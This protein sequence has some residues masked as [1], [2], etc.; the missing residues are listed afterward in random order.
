MFQKNIEN[1]RRNINMN[2]YF[3]IQKSNLKRGDTF[4]PEFY[5][6]S[7]VIKKTNLKKGVQYEQLGNNY[8]SDGEHSAIPR[9]DK[10]GIRYLY[11]RNI[12]E[13]EID[14]D[15]IS[16]LPY[17]D[18]EDYNKMTRTHLQDNDVLTAIVG[19][20][21]KSAIY[22]KE[23]VG[24]A[25]IPRHIAK[26]RLSND[27]KI[28]PEYLS[29]F[30]R[31][32]YGKAQL[33]SLTT[34]NL[35]PLLSLKN[36]KTVEIPI[37]KSDIMN[38]ITENERLSN[39]YLIKSNNYIKE[40]QE[41]F[42]ESLGFDIKKIKGD[43]SFNIKFNQIAKNDI[44]TPNHYNVKFDNIIKELDKNKGYVKLGD[45]IQT[46]QHGDEIG[47]D[48]YID[49]INKSNDS[50]PFIR[51]SDIVNYKVDQYPDYYGDEEAYQGIKQSV[52]CNDVI[53]TKDGKIGSVGLITKNDKCILSSGI[54]ILRLNNN[55][56]KQGLT[57]EYLFTAL[58]IIEIGYYE[59]IRRTVIASTIPHLRPE[60]MKEIE[61][62]LIEKINI[63]KITELIKKAFKL[64]DLRI[65]LLKENDL[66]MENAF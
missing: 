51:T 65:P 66:L 62:P 33:Y 28:T 17:I 21:G 46:M 7:E 12:R 2:I 59:A 8:V 56:I 63:D 3:S 18:I 29:V 24:V 53:F 30:L 32:K 6:Y 36:L 48:N 45:V 37:A 9:N 14:Y 16:D 43:F 13:G 61:I 49:Y 11:G 1:G 15:P 60:R 58:S 10:N 57:Q 34:G 42:Y 27:S 38:K 40:A 23:Y 19:T 5:Y 55:G 22:K 26:I 25:G 35:Q 64:K 31:S 41:I 54:E 20:V 52:K 4:V 44:W 50:Y 39:E 47:S